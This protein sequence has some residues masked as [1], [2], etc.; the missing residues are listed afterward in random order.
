MSFLP[1]IPV[2]APAVGFKFTAD[3]RP[4]PCP[5]NTVVAPLA[6]DHPAR[7][8]TA[9]FRAALI[10][11]PLGPVLAPTPVGSHH[12]TVIEGVLDAVRTPDRW[13]ADLPLDTPLD[14]VTALWADRLAD[15]APP[16]APLRL[17]VAGLRITETALGLAL[18][19]ADADAE[20][21]L[22]ALRDRIAERLALGHRPGHGSYAFHLTLAYW[23]ARP[24]RAVAETVLAGLDAEVRRRLPTLT[25]EVAEFCRF[26]DMFGFPPRLRLGADDAAS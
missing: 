19:G 12:M 10:G 25:L 4:L 26:D 24:D 7:A 8:T 20:A 22:R 18:E 16:P 1:E 9:A 14:A 2:P 11:S 6:A 3:G 23:I 21:E 5:G 13:P 15:F 17:R